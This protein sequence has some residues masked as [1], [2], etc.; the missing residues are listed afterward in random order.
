MVEQSFIS[1]EIVL[2]IVIPCFNH[3][4]FILETLNSIDEARCSIPYEII[5]VN[6]GST[7]SLTNQTLAKLDP[8]KYIL[9]QQ[10]NQGLASARNNGIALSRGKYILPL[11]SDN[12]VHPNYLDKSIEILKSNPSIDV[13]Y[14]NPFYFGEID[15]F[16]PDGLKVVGDFDFSKL[17]NANY[18]DACAIFKKEIWQK[19]GGYDKDMPVMGHEDW[20]FWIKIFLVNGTFYYL[21]DLCFYYRKLP[22]SMLVSKAIE[23]HELN[24]KYIYQKHNYLILEFLNKEIHQL[25]KLNFYLKKYKYRS[26]IK[27]LLGMKLFNF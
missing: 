1:H 22:N 3:G 10:N 15:E 20:E 25:K 4:S 6:D 19:V 2:S 27:I 13:L 9:L 17:V 16:R 8:T 26:I 14:G 5:I 11:D 23:I 18:I 24:K 21:N 7:D 12:K